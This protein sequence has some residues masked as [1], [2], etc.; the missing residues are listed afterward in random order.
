MKEMT[1]LDI[2]ND[3]GNN[4]ITM[5]EAH[6]KICDLYI[7]G[8]SLPTKEEAFSELENHQ[9]KWKKSHNEKTN[10]AYALGFRHCY[11][12]I[13]DWVKVKR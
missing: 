6:K 2:L 5:I 9:N 1:L 3:Y 4:Y 12:F 8:G 10:N 7:V 11:H 13:S